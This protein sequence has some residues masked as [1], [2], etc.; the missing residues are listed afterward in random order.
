MS[1]KCP[2]YPR[3][4]RLITESWKDEEFTSNLPRRVSTSQLKKKKDHQS[5]KES[6]SDERWQEVQTHNQCKWFR[7]RNLSYRNYDI[8]CLKKEEKNHNHS[9]QFQN[10]KQVGHWWLMPIISTTQEAEIQGMAFKATLSKKISQ[11]SFHPT[12]GYDDVCVSSSYTGS[13]NR[14]TM[15]PAGW[16]CAWLKW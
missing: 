1:G 4:K 13:I 8:Q 11:I 3:C 5:S 16:G 9:Q 7:Y 12:A 2:L 14:R 15:I 6:Q 10:R